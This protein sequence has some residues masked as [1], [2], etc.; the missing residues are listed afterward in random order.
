VHEKNKMH[1][2]ESIFDRHPRRLDILPETTHG[3]TSTGT[4]ADDQK[5]YENPKL[6]E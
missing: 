5:Q 1:R 4:E 3:G 6:Y 2:S